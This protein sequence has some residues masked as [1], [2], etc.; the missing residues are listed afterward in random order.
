MKPYQVAILT[1]IAVI[2]LSEL[3]SSAYDYIKSNSR[4][5][6]GQ[7]WMSRM[8]VMD[9]RNNVEIG[10][11]MQTSY[12][13]VVKIDGDEITYVCQNDTTHYVDDID[14]FTFNGPGYTSQKVNDSNITDFR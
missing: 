11:K 2:G 4:V 10:T 14:S 6:V 13:K 7:I 5:K 9:F 12:R 3:S 8:S 1:I